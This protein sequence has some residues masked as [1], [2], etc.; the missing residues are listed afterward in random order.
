MILSKAKAKLCLHVSGTFTLMQALLCFFTSVASFH[1]LSFSTW[2]KT[3]QPLL[4]KAPG[5][6]SRYPSLFRFLCCISLQLHGECDFPLKFPCCLALYWLSPIVVYYQ[7][8][9]QVHSWFLCCSRCWLETERSLVNLS[10]LLPF[11]PAS[12]AC[13]LMWIFGGGLIHSRGYFTPQNT[14]GHILSVLSRVTA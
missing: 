10:P 7:Q 4:P 14:R 2:N 12:T 13:I 1:Y 11:S 6:T 9:W 8:I 5:S 3:N